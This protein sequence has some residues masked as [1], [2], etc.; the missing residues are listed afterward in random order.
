MAEILII[1]G[2]AKD[3]S[4]DSGGKERTAMLAEALQ[5][6]NVTFL[7]FNWHG[8][9]KAE[10]VYDNITHVEVQIDS[11]VERRYRRLIGGLVKSNYDAAVHLLKQELTSFTKKVRQLSKQADLVILDHYST[12][13]FLEDVP[14]NVP[15]IYNSHNAEIIMAKQLYPKE[16]K[17]V[18]AVEAMEELALT[19]ANAITYC[20]VKDFKELREIY[21]FDAPAFYVPNG[22]SYNKNVS[23]LNRHKSKDI[24]FVGSGHPPNVVAAKNLIAVAE[25]LPE[26]NFI[27]CGGA[28]GNL[29]GSG[30]KNYIAK[31]FV[32]D[33]ELSQLFEN[34]F[35]F[36]NPMESGSGT[37][38]KVMR[39]LGNGMPI[40]TS[41]V[42]ARGFSDEEISKSMIIANT[43]QEMVNAI[44][45]LEN[46]D[47]FKKVCNGSYSVSKSYSWKN[48]Q[49]KYLEIV[50]KVIADNPVVNKEPAEQV[51]LN[52]TKVLIYS[53]IRNRESNISSYHSQIK[54]FVG[55]LSDYEFYLSVYENDSSDGTRRALFSKDWSF[56]SGISIVSENINTP[57]FGSVKNPTRVELL[58]NARNKAIVSGDFLDKVEYVLMVEGDVEYDTRAVKSLLNFKDKEPNFDIVSSISLRK[59]NGTHYDWWATRTGPEF[60]TEKSEIEEDYKNKDY[61]RYYSTSNGLCLYRAK[62]FQEGARHHWINKVTNEFDCEMV[63]LCQ[64]FQAR[65]YNNIFINYRSKTIHTR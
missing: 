22:T 14:H 6:H 13:P 35:A 40:I 3:W 21:D 53:I 60:K 5:G 27:L 59:Q 43:A 47:E 29:Q 31:G 42:G 51:V 12:A 44:R 64:D 10:Q 61:G 26:Y 49:T 2:N 16:Q 30:P 23:H 34:S 24:L 4:K 1:S 17:I 25:A 62:P 20:S 15:V 45:K 11:F 18:A 50:N 58:S 41:E 38:L 28:T 39:A 57:Y 52:K 8:R 54:D 36:I 56:L 65:G 46:I 63:V 19:R 7:S 48:I 33:E 55:A 32:D 9:N 37:H